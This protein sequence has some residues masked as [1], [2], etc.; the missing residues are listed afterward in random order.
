LEEVPGKSTRPDQ[1]SDKTTKRDLTQLRRDFELHEHPEY[2]AGG[3]DT[4]GGF[5][6]VVQNG[7]NAVI[8]TAGNLIIGQ[9]NLYVGDTS[10][11]PISTTNGTHY[12][13][14]SLYY[15]SG[16]STTLEDLTTLP[17]QSDITIVT[18]DYPCFRKLLATITVAE[19]IITEVVQQQFGEIV[20]G[21]RLV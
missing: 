17:D 4:Y 5:F 8:I 21:G 13:C 19:G 6:K 1:Y 12:L 20:V 3:G 16:Y 7:E 11:V 10:S 14:F 9:S 18:T 15:A 2:G